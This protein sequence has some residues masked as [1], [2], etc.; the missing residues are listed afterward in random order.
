MQVT[1]KVTDLTVIT[2]TELAHIERFLTGVGVVAF[3][4]IAFY[5][6]YRWRAQSTDERDRLDFTT[7]EDN[8]L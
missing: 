1:A 6:V 2:A 4:I 8:K 3:A 5:C 7:E